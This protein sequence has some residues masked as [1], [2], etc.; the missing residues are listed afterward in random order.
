MEAL[1][2]TT[3]APPKA[4]AGKANSVHAHRMNR[5]IFQAVVKRMHE[6]PEVIPQSLD[7]FL[8][9]RNFERI[10]DHATNIAEDVIFWVRGSDVRHHASVAAEQKA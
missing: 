3:F 8:I 10:G 2:K 7:A 6:A 5:E 1:P 4:A 9:A